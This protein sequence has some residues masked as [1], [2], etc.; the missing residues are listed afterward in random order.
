[1]RK[2]K[3]QKSQGLATGNVQGKGCPVGR[4]KLFSEP[5]DMHT[6]TF[7]AAFLASLAKLEMDIL[8]LDKKEEYK[9]FVNG[10]N[11]PFNQLIES[12]K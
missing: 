4:Q 7:T 6:C 11:C 1:M 10:N 8:M 5:S 12:R 9:M 3:H 2:D